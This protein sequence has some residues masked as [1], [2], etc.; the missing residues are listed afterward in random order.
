MA[1]TGEEAQKR[2][3]Q[4]VPEIHQLFMGSIPQMV[5]AAVILSA[6]AAIVLFSPLSLNWKWGVDQ[7]KK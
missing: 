7:S 3:P 6:I 4:Y 1:P 2:L 5:K